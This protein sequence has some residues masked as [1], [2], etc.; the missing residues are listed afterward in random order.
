MGQRLVEDVKSGRA[1]GTVV[2]Q[3]VGRPDRVGSGVVVIVLETI[4]VMAK[5]S[6]DPDVG[7]NYEVGTHAQ[8]VPP[9]RPGEIV[10]ELVADFLGSLRACLARP[11]RYARPQNDRGCV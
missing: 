3:G 2:G 6:E 9:L 11:K 8:G 5:I 1:P 4:A 7:L 10:A